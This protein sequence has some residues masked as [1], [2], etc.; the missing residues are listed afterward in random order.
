MESLMKNIMTMTASLAVALLI[1]VNGPASASPILAAS[2]SNS[3]STYEFYSVSGGIN[4]NDANAYA[5]G[6][7]SGAH[8]AILDSAAE[9]SFVA[10]AIPLSLINS[11]STLGP[12]IGASKTSANVPFK[13]VNGAVFAA[14]ENGN[15]AGGQPDAFEGYPTAVLF[16]PNATGKW[17]DY[18]VQC[19]AGGA[20]GPDVC[21]RLDPVSG[22]VVERVPEPSTVVMSAMALL[23]LFGVGMM[24]RR[25]EA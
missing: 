7:G 14:F 20:V 12:W 22:F 18:G 10:A 9:N 4:W 11:K 1:G 6:L 8:L 21:D 23:S 24:R 15:W 2:I 25:T 19:G 13:W 5:L 16:Y 17:G 3:G